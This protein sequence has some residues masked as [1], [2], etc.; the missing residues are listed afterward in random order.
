M[1]GLSGLFS[2]VSSRR[3]MV[4]FWAVL[5]LVAALAIAVPSLGVFYHG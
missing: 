4:V 5:C 2:R 1:F 3:A